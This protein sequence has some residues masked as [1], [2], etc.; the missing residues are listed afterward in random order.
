VA[1]RQICHLGNIAGSQGGLYTIYLKQDSSG[2]IIVMRGGSFDAGDAG[3]QIGTTATGVIV[4]GVYAHLGLTVR[5]SS[6]SSGNLRVEW[7]VRKDGVSV[8]SGDQTTPTPAHTAFSMNLA[9]FGGY[10]DGGSGVDP[11]TV[12]GFDDPHLSWDYAAFLDRPEVITLHPHGVGAYNEWQL[13]TSGLP[14]TEHYTYVDELNPV[15]GDELRA[16]AGTLRDTFRFSPHGLASATIHAAKVSLEGFADDG[17][18]LTPARVEGLVR[19]GGV[20]Y[21]VAAVLPA[22]VWGNYYL[23]ETNPATGLAWTPADVSGAEFGVRSLSA[24]TP[25][26]VRELALELLVTSTT[27]APALRVDLAALEVASLVPVPPNRG[28]I[29]IVG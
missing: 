15:L 7:E 24:P 14:D 4:P 17:G 11:N 10:A 26:H 21:P 22:P 5:L 1:A 18:G 25:L 8:A 19:I 27:P 23:M 16:S 28:Y 13:V 12:Q 3:T 20:D 2:R 6:P 29:T 9:G